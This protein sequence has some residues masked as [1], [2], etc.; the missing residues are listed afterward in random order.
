MHKSV[1][2]F[3]LCPAFVHLS[4]RRRKLLEARRTTDDYRAAKESYDQARENFQS[5]LDTWGR[6]EPMQTQE[7]RLL[8][9]RES[10][11]IPYEAEGLI[12]QAIETTFQNW[13][14]GGIQMEDVGRDPQGPSGSERGVSSP[15]SPYVLNGRA[16]RATLRYPGWGM[17]SSSQRDFS[18]ETKAS[19]LDYV[20]WSL[21]NVRSTGWQGPHC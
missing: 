2:S 7:C 11:M 3:S 21:L 19:H 8:L 13:K 4:L 5:V 10:G 9:Q 17:K 12:D 6:V 16:D 20:R 18:E 1:S 15:F 14:L